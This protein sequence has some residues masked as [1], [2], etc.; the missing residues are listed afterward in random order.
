M[1]VGV[2]LAADSKKMCSVV[3]CSDSGAGDFDHQLLYSP[4]PVKRK[5][6]NH[7][8]LILMSRAGPRGT[9]R[10]I[11]QGAVPGGGAFFGST[12]KKTDFYRK[13]VQN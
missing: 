8:A 7:L 9:S 3:E 10:T 4:N 5:A 6:L 1:E 12:M 13:N 2:A 11:A